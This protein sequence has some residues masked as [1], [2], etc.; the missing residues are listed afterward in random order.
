MK[1]NTSTPQYMR[2]PRGHVAP[3]TGN[4]ES[5]HNQQIDWF[6]KQD[7]AFTRKY[8]AGQAV[9]EDSDKKFMAEASRRAEQDF[10]PDTGL[11]I[12]RK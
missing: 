4:Q 7:R 9:F 11:W 8:M 5:H 3:H 12:N 1:T 2:L 6:E 10:D